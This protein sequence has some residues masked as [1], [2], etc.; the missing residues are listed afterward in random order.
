MKNHF[1]AAA[2]A[3]L[4]L[5][6]YSPVS[7]QEPTAPAQQRSLNVTPA[8]RATENAASH[9]ENRTGRLNNRIANRV[10]SRIQGRINRN[11]QQ[12]S[13]DA[14]ASIRSAAQQAR[15]ATSPT[16]TTGQ[17]DLD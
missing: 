2:A 17:P 8:Q 5:G 7:A 13:T 16:G 10:S 6:A 3:I 15:T 14:G 1:A 4:F 9:T 11:P 12:Q